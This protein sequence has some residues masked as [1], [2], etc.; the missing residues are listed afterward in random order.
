MPHHQSMK[1][2]RTVLPCVTAWLVLGDP[3]ALAQDGANTRAPLAVRSVDLSDAVGGVDLV[4]EID[5]TVTWTTER[6]ADGSLVLLLERS[7]PGPDALNLNPSTGLVSSVEVGFAVPGGVPTTRIVVSGRTGFDHDIV[8]ERGRLVA[9]LRSGEETTALG[10][11]SAEG[12]EPAPEDGRQ[13]SAEAEAREEVLRAGERA[14]GPERELSELRTRLADS[15]GVRD[16][17]QASLNEAAKE[18]EVHRQR[19]AALH[20][21]RLQ[22]LGEL[23]SARQE[24]ARARGVQAEGQAE[25]FRRPPNPR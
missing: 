14:E 18:A 4:I 11:A 7:V 21:D 16:Q 8:R 3:A 19:A 5:E 23:E 10:R 1:L 15:T 9:R 17:L 22:L 20:A 2:L 13:V 24:L 25:E 6:T 12:S